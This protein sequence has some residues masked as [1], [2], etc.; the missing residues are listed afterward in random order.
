MFAISIMTFVSLK[1]IKPPSK[2]EI[3]HS[4]ETWA[5]NRLNG[6]PAPLYLILVDHGSPSEFLL[7]KEVLTPTEF[8][9]LAKQFRK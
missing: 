5:K 4:I 3:K 1:C 7:D 6:S 2:L 8:K 9:H